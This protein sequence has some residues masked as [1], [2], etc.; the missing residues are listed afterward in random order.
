MCLIFL[1]FKY[2]IISISFSV[3]FNFKLP[4]EKN[5]EFKFNSYPLIVILDCWL[6]FNLINLIL[7]NSNNFL[8]DKGKSLKSKK[9]LSVILLFCNNL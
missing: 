9:F 1:S 7:I 6:N 8:N 3:N 4:L 5:L 2:K